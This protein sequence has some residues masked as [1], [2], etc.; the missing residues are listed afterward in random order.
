MFT[1]S[2]RLLFHDISK[3]CQAEDSGSN[4]VTEWLGL[5]N[6]GIFEWP[7]ELFLEYQL[8]IDGMGLVDEYG[9]D[10]L[11]PEGSIGSRLLPRCRPDIS[12]TST[13]N[14]QV[15][16]DHPEEKATKRYSNTSCFMDN[17]DPDVLV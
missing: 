13:G 17:D 9:D 2:C 15:F 3:S 6:G 11:P 4:V 7:T 12:T 1:R 14:V 8:A 5:W 16:T 10:N